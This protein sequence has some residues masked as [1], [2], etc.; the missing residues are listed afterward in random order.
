MLK[1]VPETGTHMLR[2]Q[3]DILK[4]GLFSS[5]KGEAFLRTNLGQAHLIR[6]EI[7]NQVEKG[8]Q[9]LGRDWFD[10]PMTPLRNDR[11]EFELILPLLETGH[12]QAKAFLLDPVSGE[13]FW[14][15]GQNVVIN[16]EPSAYRFGNG[17]YCAFV[18]QFGRNKN[19]PKSRLKDPDSQ[20]LSIQQLE[21]Q[22]YAVIPPSGS[23]RDLIK[24]LDHVFFNLKC[25]IL[26]LLPVHP[27]PTVFGRMG[28]FGSPY[29]ALD[30]FSVDP[31]L[32]EFDSKKTP[33]DQFLE[34]VDGVHARGGKL[35]IDIALNH[36]GWAAKLHETHPEW[37]RR[38][39]DGSFHR[40]GAWG[41]TWSDLTELEHNRTDLW[42]YLAEVLLTW[43]ERGVDG[44][45]CDAGY[46]IP[47]EAWLY[48]VAR[49]RQQFPDTVFLLEGL[50]G[51][52]AITEDLINTCNLDW[53]YSELFQNYSRDDIV[54]YSRYAWRISK[55]KG[56]LTH[57]AE[58]HDNNRLAVVSKSYSR[59][60]VALCA[61][62]SSNGAFGFA[63]G[64]EWFAEE[65]IDVHRDS[66]LNWGA[67]LN[68]IAW[69][70]ALN[71]LLQTHICF[72]EN[73][74]LEFL[75]GFPPE[76]VVFRRF[77]N[78]PSIALL[79]ALNLDP[80][81]AIKIDI[82]PGWGRQLL[83]DHPGA[84]SISGPGKITI[85]GHGFACFEYG[86]PVR[87]LPLEFFKFPALQ[88]A[89]G[90]LAPEELGKK[91][92]D[93]LAEQFFM[94]PAK[95]CRSFGKTSI[96]EMGHDLSRD[97]ILPDDHFMVI[98]SESRF[99]AKFVTLIREGNQ[100]SDGQWYAVF[101]PCLGLAKR[102]LLKR[103]RTGSGFEEI[104]FELFDG[105]ITS[106]LKARI[107]LAYEMPSAL[108]QTVVPLSPKTLQLEAC[109]TLFLDTN[110]RG[111][112]L[113]ANVHW[114]RLNSR[115]D[116][117]LAANLDPCV[118]VDRHVFLRR[119]RGWLRFVGNSAEIGPQTTEAVTIDTSIQY[120][121]VIP[122]GTGRWIRLFAEMKM[123]PNKNI[124]VTTFH[125]EAQTHADMLPDSEGVTLILRPDI[126]DRNF[127]HLTKA[128]LGPETEFPKRVS[129]LGNS[130]FRFKS[131]SGS[132]FQI[133]SDEGL[134]VS[135]PSWLYNC[136]YPLESSRGLDDHGDLFSPGYFKLNL[137]GGAF[138]TILTGL[139]VDLESFDGGAE[140]SVS[141]LGKINVNR[142]AVTGEPFPVYL[143]D[144]PLEQRLKKAI[145]QF[146]VKRDSLKTV[147]A[148][149]PWFLDWGRDTLICARGM[150]AAGYLK[151]V[152][153]ILIQ[154]GSFADKGTLPNMIHGSDASNRDTSD[155][156]LWFFRVCQ[157]LC[158]ADSTFDLMKKPLDSQRSL[159][160]ILVELA[161]GIL[162]GTANGISVDPDTG[163]VFSPS[164]FTWMDTN[165]PAGT[166]REG[167]PV[168]IQA[169]WFNA[170][171]FLGQITGNQ[172]WVELA[173]KVKSSFNQLFW[174]PKK[175]YLADCLH[176]AKGVRP[177]KAVP[178]DALRPNQ[179]LAV[180]FDLIPFDKANLVI[181]AMSRLVVPGG[182]RSLAD[183]DVLFPLPVF[184]K[185]G[186]ILNNP[187]RP[188][189][190][191]Y[192][193]DEDTRRK[194]AYHNGTAW[195]WL[196]PMYCEAMAK[197]RMAEGKKD[198]LAYLMT[199]LKDFYTGCLGH[200]P[201]ILDAYS[202]HVQRGCDAQAWSV[203]EFYR[204]LKLLS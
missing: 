70:G 22:H 190:P 59:I 27:V 94:N 159:G 137:K 114:A 82:P 3:G 112:M 104:T 197:V 30:F 172:K 101:P 73:P 50:G 37:L 1:Q 68:Q 99:R 113:R 34:L 53:A 161:E 83:V 9:M 179:V 89:N 24:E 7:I 126:E 122:V 134:F 42:L 38:N 143:I 40:P 199:S 98:K 171:V 196:F 95:F 67:E 123:L 60:R 158:E 165:Y 189:W 78:L 26:H 20:E 153:E 56:F 69:I 156:P 174:I 164:H 35:F 15:D 180:L 131:G 204:V 102:S 62:L 76:L 65:K 195:T 116:A 130:G 81:R 91:D 170:L 36:T 144:Q 125:R 173:N 124:M 150:I 57:Y 169:L 166:P 16:V 12:F 79:I 162:M 118:P 51:D 198:A 58:T 133:S 31:G 52:P 5:K 18:R 155:A 148:G 135:E 6:K 175:K 63:N 84:S 176:A 152:E 149:Y 183:Q 17:I 185:N 90:V 107:W 115:Y 96:W 191:H 128:F 33:L 188:F 49:V 193:G 168:E 138:A 160:E 182:L 71:E 45:R 4:F 203:T 47:R 121:F 85:P 194:P 201:E 202:P 192:E 8:T 75:T 145:A 29:A 177:E 10:I 167:Y 80:E 186:K 66:G 72:K 187:Q 11:N 132:V 111:A 142:S 110:N 163:L 139:A 14:P 140:N 46:M 127:H 200:L 21:K 64:V 92:P 136:L 41:V 147:I 119:W 120:C 178:G 97:F 61:F 13:T 39:P 74:D 106:H 146:I 23:F 55:E 184:D 44:F 103:N 157:D 48:L 129:L 154:F 88:A 108:K 54:R 2:F 86:G 100:C 43:C 181:E 28:R 141:S 117:L 87:E 151:D 105:V 77:V 19:L 93:Q 25:K 109:E 32:A